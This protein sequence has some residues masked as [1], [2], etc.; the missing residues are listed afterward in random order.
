MKFYLTASESSDHS[1]NAKMIKPGEDGWSESV[2]RMVEQMHEDVSNSYLI[3][4]A[5]DAATKEYLTVDV[6]K[7]S[8]TVRPE[9]TYD[10]DFEDVRKLEIELRTYLWVLEDN[11][12]DS[13][14]END[15][16]ENMR[17]YFRGVD[18]ILRGRTRR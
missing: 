12:N 8:V 14:D 16:D 9:P 17:Q 1:T 13:S 10:S 3:E 4:L 5:D 11:A 6:A 2:D 18:D 15:F 7:E